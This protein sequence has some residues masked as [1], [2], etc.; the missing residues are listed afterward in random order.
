M[1]TTTKKT[2]LNVVAKRAI[3]DRLVKA[4]FDEKMKT[5]EAARAIGIL[6][7]YI[8]IIG[9]G[10]C[11][12][13]CSPAAWEKVRC[14]I[15]SRMS[16]KKYGE[17]MKMDKMVNEAFDKKENESKLIKLLTPP[18]DEMELF[19]ALFKDGEYSNI[20]IVKADNWDDADIKL[21]NQ[22]WE[23]WEVLDLIEFDEDGICF[24]I[25]GLR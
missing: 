6:P 11:W 14:W 12:E 3:R 18:P 4:M 16:L 25:N 1:K 5:S 8:Y 24:A 13:K 17:R 19:I 21:R 9:S 7:S 23:G 2:A 10:K 22:G 15:N 20:L